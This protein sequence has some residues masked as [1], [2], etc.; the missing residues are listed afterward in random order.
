LLDDNLTFEDL[1]YPSLDT[2]NVNQAG[3]SKL[4]SSL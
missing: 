3:M 4:E 2:L 1:P